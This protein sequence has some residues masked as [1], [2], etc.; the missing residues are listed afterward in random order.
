MVIERV[1]QCIV[2]IYGEGPVSRVDRCP[3][4]LIDDIERHAVPFSEYV[5]NPIAPDK[6][7]KVY[8]AWCDGHSRRKLEVVRE[9][10]EVPGDGLSR[11]FAT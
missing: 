6:A 9:I 8:E 2:M 5:Q 3:N 4:V 11:C 10:S 7:D 1:N